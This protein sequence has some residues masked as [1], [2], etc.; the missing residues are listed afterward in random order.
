MLHTVNK[1]G[2]SSKLLEECLRTV[3]ADDAILLIEDGVYNALK[4]AR[5][6]TD[7]QAQ[8][9]WYV[10]MEDAKARGLQA[11][12]CHP[13]IQWVDYSGFVELTEQHA[14]ICSWF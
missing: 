5:T 4:T 11:E 8:C 13:E 14:S 9:T 3:Q 12:H 10:L 2:F 1:S 7:Q 6:F